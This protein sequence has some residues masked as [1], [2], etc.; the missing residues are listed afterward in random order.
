MKRILLLALLLSPLVAWGYTDYRG[1]NLDSLERV[2]A[3]YTPDKLAS[4]SKE[5]LVDY[6]MLC[7][8]LTWGYLQLDATKCTYYGRQAIRLGEQLGGD[9]TV[10]DASI[11]VGQTFWAREQYDSARVYYNKAAAALASMESDNPPRKENDLDANRSRLWGT[12]GNFYAVQDSIEQ[13]SFYY[14]KAAEIFDKYEDYQQNAILY[15]NLGEIRMDAGDKKQAKA[16]YDRSLTAARQSGDSLMVAIARKGQGRWYKENGQMRKA[17]QCLKEAEAYYANHPQEEAQ[18]RSETLDYMTASYDALNKNMRT[19]AVLL[20]L[21]LASAAAA[22]WI[23]FRLKRTRKELTETAAVLDETIEELRP[24]SGTA[25]TGL[26]LTPR[27]KDVVRLLM[28]DKST[29]MIADELG[30]SYETVVWY[31]KRLLAKF[32]V[33]TSPALIAEVTRRGLL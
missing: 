27:E 10:F 25:P 21:L 20:A 1:R 14:N 3:R 8:E 17:L 19:L 33:H 30:V 5:E 28:Q 26:K 2:A 11:L 4:T 24:E 22:F 16:D 31:R 15:Y 7:R 9:M 32:D 29:K 18:S 6:A 23:V 12:M 13:A